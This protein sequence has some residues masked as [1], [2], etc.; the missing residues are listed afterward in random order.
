MII[1]KRL[2]VIA[3]SLFLLFLIYL[4]FWPVPIEPAAWVPPPAPTLTGQYQ[5]N[6]KLAT[7]E[8]LPVGFAPEDVAIDAQHRIYAG[9]DDGQVIRLQPDGSHLE[10]FADTHGRPLGLEFDSNGNLIVADAI[11]GLVSISP[12]GVITVLTSEVDG[13]PFG[14]TN[15]LDIAKDGTIYFTDASRKFPMT[16]YK[17][18]IVESQPNGRLL[19][20]NPADKTTRMVLDN[21]CFANG[22]AVSPD[23]SFV[24]V[25][26]TA[27]YR[28]R[29]V[30]LTGL[31]QGQSDFF[32]D[33]LPG[34]P[35]GLSYNGVDRYWVALVTPRDSVLD[36]LLP[37]P[38][39]RKA[40]LR[41][42]KFLQPKPKRYSFVVALDEN[43]RVVES[44]QDGS[45]SCY[46]QIANVI[47]HDGLL[48]F[49][50]IGES[51]VGRY[52]LQN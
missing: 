41:L 11:K 26:E 23:Q 52:R 6:S 24:L 33:N 7:V 37:H 46:G 30:W 4:F 21:I 25:C 28:V 2:I 10:I 8:R 42:P 40:V 35:D 22:V 16:N 47:E 5:Q 9:L 38:F 27:R 31:K 29:R 18:D 50:S 34:F 20:Y 51:A 49:G 43:G 44:L 39:L 15:D 14:A 17:A 12:S 36:K 1:L 13:S 19:A 3:F 48:Y 45:E 32:I